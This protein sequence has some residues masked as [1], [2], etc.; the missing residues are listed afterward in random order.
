[1]SERPC[2]SCRAPIRMI[3]GPGGHYIPAQK[4]RTV[5]QVHPALPGFEDQP[6]VLERVMTGELYV[7]HFETCPD[8]SDHSRKEKA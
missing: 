6:A 4:V 3:K 8:A 5:Y 1:M 2:R 7:S